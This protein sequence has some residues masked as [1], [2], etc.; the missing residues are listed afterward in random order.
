[1]ALISVGSDCCLR[2][3]GRRPGDEEPSPQTNFRQNSCAASSYWIGAGLGCWLAF[4]FDGPATE[5]S[6]LVGSCVIEVKLDCWLAFENEGAAAG[7]SST[8]ETSVTGMDIEL[9]FWLGDGALPYFSLISFI[10]SS[11]LAALLSQ[12]SLDRLWMDF[13]LTFE[14]GGPTVVGR[15]VE[16]VGVGAVGVGTAGVGTIG[17]GS[18]GV[19]A[20]DIELGF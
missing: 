18:V 17:V 6:I 12:A 9:G 2:L 8:A 5:E 20:I 7:E 16:T 4:E 1:M 10:R 13:L 11:F 14:S 3:W 19:G 15:S